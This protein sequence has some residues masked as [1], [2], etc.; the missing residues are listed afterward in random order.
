MK[1]RAAVAT[2]ALVLAAGWLAPAHA[3]IWG[4]V[5]DHGVAHFAAEQLDERYQLFF[6]GGESFDTRDGVQ[7]P[8]AVGVP[9]TSTSKLLAFF[10]ISPGYKQVKHHLR[11]ASREQGID[12]ELLQALI[13]TESGFDPLAVSPKGAVGL[14]QV[15][16]ATAERYGVTGDRKNSI[17]TKL[18]DPRTNI[19]AGARY[20]RDLI[21]MFPGRLELAVAAY[22]AGEGAV[23]R[24]GNR[25]PNFRETQNYVKT[26]MQLYAMLKPPA[27]EAGGHAPQRVQMEIPGPAARRNVPAGMPAAA[28]APIAAGDAQPV[29]EN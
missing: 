8:R 13:A 5:D 20:L 2:V 22:N 9:T 14:M 12:M 1:L 21:R 23:Q 7:T 18:T 26:V 3:A 11:E 10:D 29:L 15:M 25:V 16:P 17:A 6:R 4:Y 19:R 24:A 28:V 27:M